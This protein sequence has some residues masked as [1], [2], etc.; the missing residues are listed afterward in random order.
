MRFLCVFFSIMAASLFVVPPMLG[1]GNSVKYYTCI[2]NLVTLCFIRVPFLP[3][4]W[5]IRNQMT[6]EA[7]TATTWDALW[8]N[9]QL[10]T[11]SDVD[12]PFGLQGDAAV[13]VANGRIIW[14]G[15]TGEISPAAFASCPSK[16]DCKGQLVT[17]GLIDCHTH[18]VYGGHRAREFE[19]RLNGASYEEI[20]RSGGGIVSTVSATRSA[21]SDELMRQATPRLQG[22]IAEGVTTVEIKSGY[23]LNTVDEIKMLRVARTLGKNYSV[24]VITSFLGAHTVPTEFAGRDDAYIDLVCEEMLPAVVAENLADAVDAF[25]E[26]IAFSPEQVARVFDAAKAHQLPIK[27]HAE[28]LSDLKGAVMAAKRQALSVDHIEYLAAE[29]VPV[30]AE[31]GTVAVL[32]PGAFYCLKETQLPPISALREHGVPIAIASDSNPGS[33]PVGS[34]LLMLNMA[35]RFFGL[36]PEEAL[37][38]VT[39]NAARALGIDAEVGSVEIGKRA[40]MVLWDAFEPAELSYRI[41]GNPCSRVMYKG[42]ISVAR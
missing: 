27:L 28:Q 10:A 1:E 15:K 25:C 23:G 32:L 30:L 22:L 29:D 21:T 36:T 9:A 4:T 24:D 33:S 34:L 2:Y 11:M 6:K 31:H 19:Q 42:A 26:G 20:A 3:S 12:T 38:G 14:I 13:A 41:G 35:C 16:L 37:A 5:S 39:R 18:L 7:D 40:D 8:Y 17:P